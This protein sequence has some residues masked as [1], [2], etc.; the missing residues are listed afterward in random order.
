MSE[1][2]SSSTKLSS[3]SG[4]VEPQA[5]FFAWAMPQS[6]LLPRREDATEG[7]LMYAR[8]RCDR[9]IQRAL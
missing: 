8:R 1:N 2:A 4:L 6:P 5:L 3:A 7:Q 9:I